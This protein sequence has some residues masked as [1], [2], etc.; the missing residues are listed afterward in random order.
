MV[1]PEFLAK[2]R[3]TLQVSRVATPFQE[4][5][6]ILPILSRQQPAWLLDLGDGVATLNLTKRRGTRTV[7]L[8][9]GDY[10]D[11]VTAPGSE[12]NC[13]ASMLRQLG[14]RRKRWDICDFRSLLP[15]SALLAPFMKDAEFQSPAALSRELQGLTVTLLAHNHYSHVAIPH[16]WAEYEPHIGKKLAY[17]MRAE[18]GRRDKYFETNEIRL[19][20]AETIQADFDAL[21]MLNRLR[22]NVKGMPGLF[23]DDSQC[24]AVFIFC[25]AMLE[26][27]KLR[28]YT[29]WLNSEPAGA[30]LCFAD[31]RR[32]YHYS[33]GFDPRFSKH[34]PVK[35]LIAQAIKD[36][37]I[38]GPSEFD[39]M[40]GHEDYKSDWANGERQTYRLVVAQNNLR[41]RLALWALQLQA[42]HKERRA[43]RRSAPAQPASSDE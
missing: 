41:G 29:L 24:Q 5:E 13:V 21:I 37:M 33:G 11:I 26:Q 12:V 4:P 9:G 18:Q 42:R 28:L 3:A 39:F 10:E 23:A 31:D 2:W 36:A 43:R 30:L 27:G 20:T 40:L 8:C 38:N 7:R 17:K 15:E 6:W 14:E 19:A 16:T 35:V 1:E 22:W 25:R 32:L 34:H